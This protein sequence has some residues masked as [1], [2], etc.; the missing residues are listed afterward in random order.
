MKK[1]QSDDPTFWGELNKL[2]PFPDHCT[3]IILKLEAGK[4]TVVR[5]TY[6]VNELRQKELITETYDLIKR[7]KENA[8]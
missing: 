6:F 1:L 7:K 4:D 3:K 2:I 8:R 5:A